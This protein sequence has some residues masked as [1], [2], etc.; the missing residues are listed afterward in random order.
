VK[1]FKQFINES[2]RQYIDWNKN[3]GKT[4]KLV[5]TPEG[6]QSSG[7][8]SPDLVSVVTPENGNAWTSW[9]EVDQNVLSNWKKNWNSIQQSLGDHKYEQI[10][11][12]QSKFVL[13]QTIPNPVG[14]S[15]V[16]QPT[17]QQ[18]AGHLYQT[19]KFLDPTGVLSYEDIPPAVD[20]YEKDPSSMNALFMILALAAAIPLAGKIA[21]PLKIAAKAGKVAQV[22]KL[23]AQLTQEIIKHPEILAKAGVRKE[24]VMQASTEAAR[25]RAGEIVAKS[26]ISNFTPTSRTMAG[27]V[28][29]IAHK[30]GQEWNKFNAPDVVARGHTTANPAIHTKGMYA[31]PQ[32]ALGAQYGSPATSSAGANQAKFDPIKRQKTLPMF[33][34]KDV[35]TG[36][37]RQASLYNV[38]PSQTPVFPNWGAESGLQPTFKGK[39]LTKSQYDYLNNKYRRDVN[40][41]IVPA[42]NAGGKISKGAPEWVKMKPDQAKQRQA[43]LRLTSPT[44]TLDPMKAQKALGRHA[45]IDNGELIAPEVILPQ[46]ARPFQKLVGTSQKAVPVSSSPTLRSIMRK[47]KQMSKQ[48]VELDSERYYEKKLSSFKEYFLTELFNTLPNIDTKSNWEIIDIDDYDPDGAI[49]AQEVKYYV[50]IPIK[51][52]QKVI[53]EFAASIATQKPGKELTKTEIAMLSKIHINHLPAAEVSFKTLNHPKHGDTIAMVGDADVPQVINHAIAFIRDLINHFKLN[54]VSFSASSKKLQG[55][56]N[57]HDTSDQ[58]LYS[59]SRE[60]VYERLIKRFASQM[61][62]RYEKKNIGTVIPG[63][64]VRASTD[65]ILIRNST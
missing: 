32:T 3:Y 56:T 57:E 17:S 33:K 42:A 59:D 30:H 39:P 24:A 63:S 18:A 47:Q 2:N 16:Y 52:G 64:T 20:A 53:Y 5:H 60:K 12:S 14:Y 40:P 43:D 38:K 28:Q 51:G 1:T 15:P 21:A 19:A 29:E 50:E 36:D 26:E 54:L 31:S 65:F 22:E 9:Q 35:G 6:R 25:A 27:A 8:W 62:F 11:R 4:F 34:D 44:T 37:L 10:I 46:N 48:G 49:Q 23:T 45:D 7:E 41:Y 55:D 61:G 58:H 13:E